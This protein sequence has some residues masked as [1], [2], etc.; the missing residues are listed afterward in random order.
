MGWLTG[1]ITKL[2]ASPVARSA[3][4]LVVP[5]PPTS[6]PRRSMPRGSSPS[7]SQRWRSSATPGREDATER[8]TRAAFWDVVEL[9][10]T[11]LAFGLVG[12]EVR[13][14]IHDE[15]TGN[16][17]MLRWPWPSACWSSWSRFLWFA[18]LAGLS[19][20]RRRPAADA[21]KDV[22]ILTWC[23]MRGLATLALA[24]AL[25]LT[26]AH[27]GPFPARSEIIVIACAV[28]L[29]TLVLRG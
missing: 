3:V 5:L 25:P 24:L 15:G 7:S 28:L 8:I 18:M 20:A 11:G 2:I 22:I 23:G 1:L 19:R 6:W 26:V 29:A 13:E 14:V 10:V 27:G 21:A 12:L 16:L 9:L 17:G 4:T